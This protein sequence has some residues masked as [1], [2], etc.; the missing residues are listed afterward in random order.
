MMNPVVVNADDLGLSREINEGI[1]KGLQQGVIS[2]TSLL[3]D[4]PYSREAL[5]KLEEIGFMHTGLHI[6]LDVLMGWDRPGEERFSRDRLQA[7]LKDKGFL[8]NCRDCACLQIEKFISSGLIPTHIDTHHHVHGFFP[9]FTLLAD[10][11]KEYHVPA[12]RF[13]SCGYSLTTRKPIPYDPIIYQEMKSIL[14]KESI[15]FCKEMH[16]GAGKA[17]HIKVFP[18]ELVVHPS[19]GGDPWRMR[20]MQMLSSEGCRLIREKKSIRLAGYRELIKGPDSL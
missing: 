12:M 15:Y 19:L 9:V 2:D 1:I 18:A 20:E 16:E 6:N 11:V 5:E 7:L 3:I 10:L 14:H 13:S 8:D 4:A 17:S